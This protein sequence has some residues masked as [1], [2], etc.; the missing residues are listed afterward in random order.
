MGN[1][2]RAI[3]S[4][5]SS[6]LGVQVQAYATDEGAELDLLEELKAVFEGDRIR[7]VPKGT[8]GADASKRMKGSLASDLDAAVESMR[9]VPWTTLVEL[10]DDPEILKKLEDANPY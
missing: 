3:T 7:R 1:F 5:M 8:A 4:A 9:R 6:L 2:H 10:K